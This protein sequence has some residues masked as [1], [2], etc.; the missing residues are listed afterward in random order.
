M[1]L[2]DVLDPGR[3]AADL[4][5]ASRHALLEALARLLAPPGADLAVLDA[6]NERESLGGTALGQGTALPHGRCTA[7]PAP[8]AAFARLARPVDFAAADRRLVDLVCALVVPD[9]FTDTHLLLLADIAA[10]FSDAAVCARLRA[11]PDT[12]ALYA[13]LAQ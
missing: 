13:E 1:R 3:V 10:R 11:A 2:V 9:H 8:V 4:R 5:A 7:L 6:L 12:R